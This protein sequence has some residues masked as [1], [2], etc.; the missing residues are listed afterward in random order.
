MLGVA[1]TGSGIEAEVQAHIFEPFF[2]TKE[3]GKGTGLGL[4]TVYGIVKQ[5]D[6]YIAVDSDVG[7]G[8]TFTIYLP[9]V[10]DA[11][12]P[13]GGGAAPDGSPRG[14]ETILLVEDEGDVRELAREILE[15][16][17]YA[18]LEAANG[19]DALR[20]AAR[21][22]G[23]IHLL[24]TDVV[25]PQMS[26]RELA[27]RLVR[28]RPE[29]RVLYTSGYIDENMI[30]RSVVDEDTALLKKPFSSDAL[31]RRVREVLDGRP[32]VR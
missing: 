29:V 23:V 6:G 21:H 18:V 20:I 3:H 30:R 1:D 31:V 22:E 26:G 17:G 12:E 8:T 27:R 7:R 19:P 25:M 32:P 9:R 4:S 16:S 24:L 28:K 14:E 15:K 13:V 5:H 2:T 10:E 11:V